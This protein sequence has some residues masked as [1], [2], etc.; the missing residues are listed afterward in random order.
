V[1]MEYVRRF[2]RHGLPHVLYRIDR[3]QVTDT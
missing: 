3:R 2:A 1:G